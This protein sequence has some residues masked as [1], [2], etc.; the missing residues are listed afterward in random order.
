MLFSSE[1]NSKPVSA[2]CRTALALAV[3]VPL[4]LG[5]CV[6]GLAG[7]AGMALNAV[8]G[9]GSETG[10]DAA[11][12][13][14]PFDANSPRELQDALA[15]TDDR[16]SPLCRQ[17]LRAYLRVQMAAQEASPIPETT[18]PTTSPA[19]RRCGLQPL[20]LPGADRPTEMMVCR[21]QAA[22]SLQITPQ[23]PSE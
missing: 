21:N 19:P 23:S 5:G 11:G 9:G 15:Q 12:R 18:A 4:F 3:M 10:N 16:A 13:N 22:D 1:K 14:G 8:G 17:R 7:A 2:Q 20:C 6:T